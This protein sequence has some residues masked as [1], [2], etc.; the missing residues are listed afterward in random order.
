MLTPY[1]Q[2]HIGVP[3][4]CIENLRLI[5]DFGGTSCDENVTKKFIWYSQIMQAGKV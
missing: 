1:E 3:V 4:N 2:F 5:F